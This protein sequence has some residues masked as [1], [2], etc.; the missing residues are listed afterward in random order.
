MCAVLSAL[1]AALL[2]IFLF[3]T[4]F[5]NTDLTGL[6][7]ILFILCMLGLIGALLLFMWDVNL[8]LEALRAKLKA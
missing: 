3:I 6:I 8:S 7:C 5:L 2:V 4:V 1:F